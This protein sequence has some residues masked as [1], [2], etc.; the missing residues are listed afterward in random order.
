[1][2][3]SMQDEPTTE[4]PLGDLLPL[5]VKAVLRRNGIY[6]VEEVRRAYPH[7]L[8]K[9]WGLG[10]FR[11]KQIEEVFFPGKSFTPARVYSPIRHIKDSSLNGALTPVTVQVLSRAGIMTLEQLIATTPKEL[12]E[13]KGLGV[14]KMREIETALNAR[15]ASTSEYAEFTKRKEPRVRRKRSKEDLLSEA[16]QKTSVPKPVASMSSQSE[17]ETPLGDL[18]TGQVKSVLERNGIHTVE[19]VHR[20]Y[21]H[22]LFDIPGIGILRL[23]KIEAALFPGQSF[24]PTRTSSSIVHIKRTSLN[25]ALFPGTVQ[26]LGRGGITTEEQLLA[27]SRKELLRI[28]GLG[29]VKLREIE[30]EFRL[31]LD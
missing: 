9:M 14:H 12:M 18:L 20:A 7:R 16:A 4:T 3:F 29:V 25:G 19:A 6:T 2:M 11:F 26:T 13:I 22:A 23:R 17:H 1:M 27:T 5:R 21:P 10:M 24:V 28:K 15:G 31:R 8:L 30:S